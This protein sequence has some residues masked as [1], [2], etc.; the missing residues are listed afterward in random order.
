MDLV[1]LFEFV[2]GGGSTAILCLVV[3]WLAKMYKDERQ[4]RID[5]ANRYIEDAKADQEN[6]KELAKQLERLSERIRGG[7][8]E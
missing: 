4:G 2:Q 5:D 1:Q 7:R 8:A 3:V 6:T